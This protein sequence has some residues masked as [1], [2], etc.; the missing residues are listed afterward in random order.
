MSDEEIR[1]ILVEQYNVGIDTAQ[2]MMAECVELGTK[3]E[4]GNID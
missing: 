3:I 4:R 1:D 2:E